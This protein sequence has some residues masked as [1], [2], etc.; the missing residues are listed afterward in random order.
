MATNSDQ[1][2]VFCIGFQKTGTSSLRDAL[3]QLGYSVTGVFGDDLTLEE[4]RNSYVTQGL[5]LAAE[6]DSV[7]DMPWPLMVRELDRAFP[8]SKFILTVRK[9]EN[10]LRSICKH[11]GDNPSDMQRLVYGDDAPNPVGHEDRYVEV[12]EQHNRDVI[13]YFDGRESDFLVMELEA[14]HGWAEL[15][16]FLGRADVP[17]GP[18]IHTNRAKDRDTLSYKIRTRLRKLGLPVRHMAE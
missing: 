11:F 16:K 10:W 4:L 7:E 17:G 1:P 3:R 14:G 6:F 15:G 8:G 5:S 18:F 9:T 12:Y 2:K 13:A